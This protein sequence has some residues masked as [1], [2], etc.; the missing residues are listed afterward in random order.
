LFALDKFK[1]YILGSKVIIYTD[2][3][4][5][6]FL[7][8]KA[9]SK[10]K[11]IRWMLLLQEFDIEIRDKSETHN[12]VAD[13]LSRI[14]KEED[15]SLI[16]DNF[17]DEVLLALT[18]VKCM[19]PESW[20]ADIVN[21][22]VVCAIPLSFSKSERTKLKSVAKHYVWEDPILWRIGSDQVIR[23]CAPDNKI[24]NVLE[25]CHS[26]PCGGQYGTQRTSRKV[27]DCGL[28]WPTFFKD[29]RRVYVNNVRE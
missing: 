4:A 2:H 17:P 20:F 8:N 9:D 18:Y 29:A 14:E 24:P 3:A 6:K 23:K 10:A 11:L 27:L 26:S 28:Y 12:L 22:F 13:H 25:F 21:Y 16:Q 7:L 19:F 15:D 5:L 1:S